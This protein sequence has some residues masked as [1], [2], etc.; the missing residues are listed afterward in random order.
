VAIRVP[1]TTQIRG[2]DA[3]SLGLSH[4]GL[5]TV[6][7]CEENKGEPFL[8]LEPFAGKPLDSQI[9][10][11][12]KLEPV[13][14]LALLRQLA[15]ALDYAHAHGSIHGSLHPDSILL[16]DLRE[17][18]VLD[19]GPTDTTGRNPSAEQL[20]RAVHYLSPEC[21]RDLPMDGRADQFSLAV[22]A[23]RLFTGA[24]PFAGTPLGVMF[25]I[26]YQGLERDT[27][28]DLPAAAQAVFRRSLS[29]APDGRYSTCGEMV[30]ALEGALVRR[31]VAATRVAE[32]PVFA[33]AR[34][35]APPQRSWVARHFS[36]EAVK[37]FGVTFAVCA[38]VLGALFY[39]LLPKAPPKAGPIA[40]PA[41]TP[42]P[43]VAPAAAQQT[44]TAPAPTAKARPKTHSQSIAKKKSGP[45]VELKPAEPKIIRP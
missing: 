5:M 13:D 36:G 27:V 22:L 41:V 15:S 35:P 7:S 23:H 16:N 29:K 37:Y 10:P 32:A 44:P 11:G 6:L 21:I 8:V 40:E 17:I 20:L 31:P 25:R 28:R 19:L 4:P 34:T 12:T 14:G 42:A 2:A 18:K 43:A 39:F 45:E 1:R 26:A 24:L 33:P 30:D 3:L 9:P 38:L